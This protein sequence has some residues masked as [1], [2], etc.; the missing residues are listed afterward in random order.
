VR[1][2]QITQSFIPGVVVTT[3]QSWADARCF[4]CARCVDRVTLVKVWTLALVLIAAA[5]PLLACLFV[6]LPLE[7]YIAAHRDETAIRSG[8]LPIVSALFGLVLPFVF[9]FVGIF[10]GL[11]L[12]RRRFAQLL[13]PDALQSVHERLGIKK[14]HDISF[15]EEPR[16]GSN[17]VDLTGS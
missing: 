17:P 2:L 9:A 5:L 13:E 3:T 16:L 14:I 4:C 7:S 1:F 10:G 6:Y 11:Y 12:R 8:N 15:R